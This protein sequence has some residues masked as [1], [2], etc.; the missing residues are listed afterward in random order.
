MKY[1]EQHLKSENS[2]DLLDI[3]VCCDI[4]IF[5]WLIRYACY[6]QNYQEYED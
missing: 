4:K 6:K 1:F 3:S 5:E 2:A